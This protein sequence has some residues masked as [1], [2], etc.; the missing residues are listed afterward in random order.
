[1]EQRIIDLERENA[2]LRAAHDS[3]IHALYDRI[4]DYFEKLQHPIL[5]DIYLDGREKT[6]HTFEQSTVLSPLE[7]FSIEFEFDKIISGQYDIM[8]V[9]LDE[10][11]RA[12]YFSKITYACA[13]AIEFI[14]LCKKYNIHAELVASENF[15]D[16][17]KCE[18]T[19][20]RLMRASVRK[21]APKMSVQFLIR[22]QIV[23]YR[24]PKR[25]KKT[26]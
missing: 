18:L 7:P 11:S 9:M 19:N 20:S 15:I 10:R 13:L 24:R 14:D 25:V 8:E 12:I 1:M 5:V 6:T 16:I 4:K 17:S 2:Q 21:M 23:Y 22:D 3:K 26:Q